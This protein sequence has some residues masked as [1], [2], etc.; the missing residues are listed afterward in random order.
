M[1]SSNLLLTLHLRTHSVFTT[2]NLAPDLKVEHCLYCLQYFIDSTV[3]NNHVKEKHS[4]L[5]S[6]HVRL[7][8]IRLK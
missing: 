1:F 7:I 4:T 6:F 5:I 3:L 8:H 2:G